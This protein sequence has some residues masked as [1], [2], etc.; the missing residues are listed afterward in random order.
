MRLL[1]SAILT[2]SVSSTIGYYV[3]PVVAEDPSLILAS[4]LFLPISIANQPV[5]PCK[6]QV[7]A[8]FENFSKIRSAITHRL[9]CDTMGARSLFRHRGV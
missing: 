5:F 1:S 6:K 3:F 7:D 2:Q 8:A 4:P 9:L